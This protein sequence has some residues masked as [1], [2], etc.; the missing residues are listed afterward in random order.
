MNSRDLE[1]SLMLRHVNVIDATKNIIG[2]DV[3]TDLLAI[4]KE[5]KQQLYSISYTHEGNMETVV[6]YDE[7]LEKV[8]ETRIYRSFI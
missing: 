4:E 5:L 7:I 8:I 1:F 2:K 6:I 3:G